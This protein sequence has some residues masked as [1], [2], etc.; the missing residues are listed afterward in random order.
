MVYKGNSQGLKNQASII[1]WPASSPVF[2][3]LKSRLSN[4][5]DYAHMNEDNDEMELADWCW[6]SLLISRKTINPL[7]TSLSDDS[8]HA[9]VMLN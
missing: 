4:L 3:Q 1:L 7:H 9:S 8:V 6:M 5:E 2:N